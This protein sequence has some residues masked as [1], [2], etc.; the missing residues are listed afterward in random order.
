MK[1]RAAGRIAAAWTIA[2]LA[3]SSLLLA[4]HAAADP[5]DRTLNHTEHGVELATDACAG[6]FGQMS[7]RGFPDS[8]DDYQIYFGGSGCT[9]RARFIGVQADGRTVFDSGYQTTTGRDGFFTVADAYRC[10]IEFGVQRAN[11]SF[12]SRTIVAEPQEN[13]NCPK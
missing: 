1:F 5:G 12:Y 6:A 3:T 7:V 4:P 8:P 11:G 10:S 13:P 9:V 2:A